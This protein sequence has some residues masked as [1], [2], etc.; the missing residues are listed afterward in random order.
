MATEKKHSFSFFRAGGFNQVRFATGADFIHIDE[1]D[2]KLWVA[3]SCPVKGLAFDARTLALIDTDGDGRIRAPELIAAAKWTVSL[4]KDPDMLCRSGDTLPIDAI[5]TDMEEGAAIAAAATTI[6]ASLKKTE[7]ADLS[8]ADMALATT[9]FDALPFNGDGVITELSADDDATKK[10]IADLLLCT[11]GTPDRSGRTGLNAQQIDEF[12]KNAAAY[13]DWHDKGSTPECMP[14]GAD[15]A[16]AFEAFAAVRVRIDDYFA[17]CR[18]A[19]FDERAIA[20][21]N[22]EEETFIALAAKD[23]TI[24]SDEIRAFPLA[25]VAPA[26]PLPLSEGINPAWHDAMVQFSQKVVQPLLGERPALAEA[27]WNQL[28]ARFAPYEAWQAA[29]VGAM[30]EK[31]GAPAVAALLDGDA[32]KKLDT[33]LEREKAQEPT[34]RSIASVEKLVRCRRDLF[35]LAN[36][37]V[38]FKDFYRREQPATFQVG[39]LYLDQRECHL[40]IRVDDA[41]KHAAMA[42]LSRIQLAYC[43]CTRVTTGEKMTIAAGFTAGDSDHLMVGR[44]GVFFDNEGRDWDATITKLVDNPISVRQAFWSPYKKLMRFIEE[45]VAKRASESDA[46]ANEKLVG[47]V[48]QVDTAATAGAPAPA[49][50]PAPPPP[51]KI[52]IG[53]VAALGVAVGGITAAFGMLMQAFFGLGI[54]MPVGI[55][56]VLLAI[57]GPSMLIAWL[58]LRQRNIGPLLDASGWAVNARAKVNVPLGASLTRIAALPRGSRLDKADPYAAQSHPRRWIILLVLL[59]ACAA[60]AWAIGAFD[61]LLPESLRSAV[62]PWK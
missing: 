62:L 47:G 22:R 27:E 21:L 32:R 16:A 7:G 34:A 38:S 6:L 17:R 35:R 36:N 23:L 8:V 41:A 26:Q 12:F 11:D 15:T 1:L 56:G 28:R 4:L 25:R 58:K 13:R 40:C 5:R 49:P 20:A 24:T 33:L 61:G 29:K 54:W 46:K 50:A 55:L 57:S 48:Q 53:I 2:L 19:A 18:L 31:L 52:D 60:G 51:K 3:L 30:V 39:R 45:Q 9:T 59:L 42:H 44:N 43:D 37:F 10:Y 14:L